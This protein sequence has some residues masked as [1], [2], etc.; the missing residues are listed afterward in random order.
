MQLS[1]NQKLFSQ[2]FSAFPQSTKNLE[3]FQTKDEPQKLFFSDI[4]DC[5]KWGY[6][7]AQ[8]ASCQNT[9]G[10]WTC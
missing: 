5:K 10:Q 4:I 7:N 9:F 8:K 1:L 6:V 3:Y 2:C